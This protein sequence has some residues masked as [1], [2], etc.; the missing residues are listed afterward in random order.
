MYFITKQNWKEK[1]NKRGK[2]LTPAWRLSGRVQFSI[3]SG[4]NTTIMA[5]KG[6]FL[7]PLAIASRLQPKAGLTAGSSQMTPGDNGRHFPRLIW[8][9]VP[10]FDLILNRYRG[11]ILHSHFHTKISNF[12]V[13][14]RHTENNF[15]SNHHGRK[16]TTQSNL[17]PI[18]H[19]SPSSQN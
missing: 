2:V 4:E 9:T 14:G 5:A 11:H 18:N 17:P 16:D 13:G 12:G 1:A 8:K 6:K 19:S 7:P 10:L 15:Y 3:Q